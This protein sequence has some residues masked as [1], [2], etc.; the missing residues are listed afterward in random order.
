MIEPQIRPQYGKLHV[1]I[2]IATVLDVLDRAKQDIDDEE[3]RAAALK[4]DSDEPGPSKRR[5]MGDGD[6]DHGPGRGKKDGGKWGRG[7][8]NDIRGM[9]SNAPVNPIHFFPVLC[10]SSQAPL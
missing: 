2:M 5:R 10:V 4:E 1:G 7:L 9:S 6:D 8:S 3:E